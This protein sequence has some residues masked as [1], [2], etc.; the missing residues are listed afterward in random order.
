MKSLEVCPVSSPVSG[1]GNN[2]VAVAFSSQERSFKGKVGVLS[3]PVLVPFLGFRFSRQNSHFLRGV[4]FVPKKYLEF[5]CFSGKSFSRQ[6]S[7][8]RGFVPK[9]PAG[10]VSRRWRVAAVNLPVVGH[11]ESLPKGQAFPAQGPVR[12][13]ISAI[14]IA[15]TYQSICLK[16]ANHSKGKKDSIR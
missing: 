10:P 12:K 13:K 5:G 6:N 2:R 1:S 7:H 14:S 16:I 11:C 9:M 8:A 3:V 4:S 15:F